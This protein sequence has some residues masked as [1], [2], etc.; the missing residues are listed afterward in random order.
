MKNVIINVLE[1]I[2]MVSVRDV[3]NEYKWRKDRE[4]EELEIWYT[5]R[6]ALNDTKIISGSDIH[7]IG[8]SFMELEDVMIPYH[9]VF[10]IIHKGR[11]VFER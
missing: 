6:G 7:N 3:L 8:R 11:I 2:F 4:L 9:R 10:K 5:H 1:D